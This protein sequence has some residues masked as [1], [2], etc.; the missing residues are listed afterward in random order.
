MNHQGFGSKHV[1]PTRYKISLRNHLTSQ[2]FMKFLKRDIELK[3]NC[4][5]CLTKQ[6]TITSTKRGIGR[7]LSGLGIWIRGLVLSNWR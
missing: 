1:G 5:Q 2:P 6:K 4:T 3:L 7:L